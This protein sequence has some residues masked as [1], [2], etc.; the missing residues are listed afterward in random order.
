MITLKLLPALWPKIIC[1]TPKS[2]ETVPLNIFLLS[3][4]ES[5]FLGRVLPWHVLLYSGYYSSLVKGT[6]SRD[7]LSLDFIIIQTQ[8]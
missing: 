3:A 7:F 5:A 4:A 6:L 2:H 1:S 8:V